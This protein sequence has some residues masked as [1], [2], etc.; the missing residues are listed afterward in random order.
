MEDCNR[1]RRLGLI[2]NPIA[3]M[4]GKPGLKGTDGEGRAEE[5]RRLGARPV[6]PVRA[7]RT[8][9]RLAPALG[10]IELM[11]GRGRARREHRRRARC[12]A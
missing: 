11:T 4:G 1:R 10:G 12:H 9:A 7:Q 6:A 3:G 8:L 5:A 2:V